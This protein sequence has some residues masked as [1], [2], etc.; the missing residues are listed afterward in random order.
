MNTVHFVFMGV[1]GCGKTTS[2][3]DLQ[4]HLNC[5]YAE[6]DEFHTQENRDKMG[7]GI[8]LTDEDRYP[9]LRN[10]RDWMSEQARAGE[11]YSIVTCSALKRQYR[12]IL[13]EAEGQTVFIHLAPPYE[14][15][16]ERLTARKGH[17]MKAG[18][19]DSQIAILEELQPDETGVRI[20]NPGSA[21]EVEAEMM[22]WVKGQGLIKI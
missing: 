2:A 11:A 9:W 12:D 8:P 3:I 1:T 6:G 20:D 15:N 19:L 21:E 10:L 18:M 5:P 22:E 14:V 7:A 13:R 16:L 17:Y 4:K